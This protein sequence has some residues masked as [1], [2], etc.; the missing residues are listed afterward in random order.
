MSTLLWVT[1]VITCDEQLQVQLLSTYFHLAWALTTAQHECRRGELHGAARWWTPFEL[2]VG[3]ARSPVDPSGPM[4]VA[5][6][7]HH[8]VYHFL[9]CFVMFL[10]LKC[11]SDVTFV[12]CGVGLRKVLIVMRYLSLYHWL[13]L[14]WRWD[15]AAFC[16]GEAG[17]GVHMLLT[18]NATID[19]A[20]RRTH[21][22]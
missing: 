10:S 16:W 3:H 22:F 12:V 6:C 5:C 17:G 13:S 7:V 20:P 21:S 2:V 9:G 4:C 19:A 1:W 8:C 15:P 11:P 18:V 14:P